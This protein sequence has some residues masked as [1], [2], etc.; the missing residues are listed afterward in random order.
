M[1][2]KRLATLVAVIFLPLTLA[3]CGIND[4]PTKE[5]AAKAKWADVQSQYQRRADLVPNLVETVKGYAAQERTVL[6]E[7]VSARARA[8]SIN[9]TSETPPTA[10]Q[11]EQYQSA[12]AGLSTALGRLLAVAE[13]YP[14]LKSN[15]NFLELQHQLEGTENRIQ[16]ARQ[17]YNEAVRAYNTSLRTIPSSW[18]KFMYPESKPMPLFTA[19]AAAQSAPTVDFGAPNPG[20]PAVPGAAPGSAPPATAPAQ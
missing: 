17:D 4:I 2:A 7:V 5:E 3:A 16:V 12:Q 6:N 20:Q 13:A 14:D 8:T 1:F 18:W 15:Q 11:L 10:A 9:I 19:N